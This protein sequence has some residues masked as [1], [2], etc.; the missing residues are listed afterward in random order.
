MKMLSLIAAK[1][2]QVS[3]HGIRRKE[4]LM[5][6]SLASRT[7]VALAKITEK[8]WRTY[9]AITPT[10]YIHSRARPG[11]DSSVRKV[12]NMI[13]GQFQKTAFR[14]SLASC[15]ISTDEKGTSLRSGIS[16]RGQ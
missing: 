10:Y 13:H 4:D 16:L 15:A 12:H 5:Y 3:V 11:D 8:A 1:S 9:T 2:H 7:Q 6:S 14:H